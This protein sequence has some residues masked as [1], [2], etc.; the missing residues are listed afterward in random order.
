MYRNYSFLKIKKI[1]YSFKAL[2]DN[3][4]L[5]NLHAIKF[6]EREM[7]REKNVLKC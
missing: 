5:S 2:S 6:S 7:K 4:K 1:K 3:I